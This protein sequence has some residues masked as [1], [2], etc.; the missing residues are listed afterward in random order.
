MIKILTNLIFLIILF[1]SAKAFSQDEPWTLVGESEKY[2]VFLNKDS[3]K[4]VGESGTDF[5][6]W[7]KLECIT[8][9]NDGYKP[10]SY[11]IQNWILYCGK[12]EFMVPKSIDHYNDGEVSTF[13][14]DTP[15]QILENSPGEKVYNHFCNKQDK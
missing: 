9:C 7:L 1:I 13:T 2:R 5:D 14:M 3:I 4:N 8:E 12:K 11:S 15:T 10:L 6:I